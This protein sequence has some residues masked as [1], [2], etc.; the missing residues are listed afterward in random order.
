MET[1]SLSNR[2]FMIQFWNHSILF[3]GK[4]INYHNA[5]KYKPYILAIENRF[6]KE[7]WTFF[8]K[9]IISNLKKKKKNISTG[10]HMISYFYYS[11]LFYFCDDWIEKE[12]YIQWKGHAVS[13]SMGTVR[14]CFYYF[15][16]IQIWFCF[17]VMWT[18]KKRNEWK[19]KDEKLS[20]IK[21]KTKTP[22]FVC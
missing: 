9:H 21:R 11:F 16:L 15:I 1:D 10:T 13:I 6:R 18:L 12:N 8:S 14:Y 5:C 7:N 20:K 22:S 2:P 3:R 4:C 17:I 19:Y